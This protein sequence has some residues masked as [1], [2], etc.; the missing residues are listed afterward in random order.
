MIHRQ[1]YQR[2]QPQNKHINEVDF[3]ILI[4]DSNQNGALV[5]PVGMNPDYIPVNQRVF[6]YFKPDRS[7]DNNGEWQK[8]SIRETSDENVNRWPGNVDAVNH[9]FG[10]DQSFTYKLG[11]ESSRLTAVM[12]VARG[13]SSLIA[14]AGSDNDWAKG[15]GADAAEGAAE[16]YSVLFFAFVK[17]GFR[18]LRVK[19]NNPYGLRWGRI[20]YKAAFIRLGTNDCKTGVWNQANFIAGVPALVRQLRVKTD[21]NLPIY[22]I[23]VRDD[24]EDAP[25]GE[26]TETNVDQVRDAIA[27][28]ASGGS[29]AITGFNVVTYETDG[30]QADGVHFDYDAYVSQGENEADIVLGL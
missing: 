1:L 15:T 6:I 24:L 23:Q 13:G 19:S 5:E 22:W 12:K 18:H 26:F 16:L 28:C 2:G 29:T 7:Y 20:K 10:Q 9:Y 21:P 4:G 30:L 14:Q 17:N 25:G 8:Y 3:V 11:Q 27:D